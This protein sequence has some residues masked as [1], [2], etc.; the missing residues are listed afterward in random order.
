MDDPENSTSRRLHSIF[1]GKLGEK[2]IPTR[3]TSMYRRSC[4]RNVPGNSTFRFEFPGCGC[5]GDARGAGSGKVDTGR[6]WKLEEGADLIELT[7]IPGI[8]GRSDISPKRTRAE[9]LTP[10][11][12]HK[13]FKVGERLNSR[14][15]LP[16]DAR[17]TPRTP[18]PRPTENGSTRYLARP[19]P[20]SATL[21]PRPAEL[22]A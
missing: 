4:H 15:P 18:A 17:K 21:K 13:R 8:R 1:P 14:S 3:K 2:T 5:E 11:F 10:S 19:T 16:A 6:A 7:W 9:R 12:P 20:F 22:N